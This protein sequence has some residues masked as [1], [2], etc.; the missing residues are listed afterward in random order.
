VDGRPM[1][2][3]SGGGHWGGGLVISAEDH[4]RVGHLVLRGGRWDGR[5]VLPEGW[6]R[7]LAEPCPLNPGYGLLWW[8]NPNGA[9]YPS[10]PATSL[11]AIGMGTNLIWIDPEHDLV[12]VARWIA[13]DRVDGFIA[14]V[15]ASLT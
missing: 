15:M 11:F 12:A 8:L 10:A 5:P 14:R 6:A 9:T 4:A 13:R 7:T 3:V 1:E 2:S